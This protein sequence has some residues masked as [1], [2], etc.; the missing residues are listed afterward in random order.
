MKIIL[1]LIEAIELSTFI[2]LIRN[3]IYK[4]R[5]GIRTTG[6]KVEEKCIPGQ[7]NRYIVTVKIQLNGI[8]KQKRI[9]TSDK[10][11]SK[12]RNNET[13]SLVYVEK[14][15]KRYWAEDKS[16]E[17]VVLF[18][19]LILSMMILAFCILKLC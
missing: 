16:I 8:K 17:I 1:I 19:L 6:V 5:D 4:I 10:R 14:T 2:Y 13:L 18:T 9:I 7:P 15:R 3:Q 11:I 12:I